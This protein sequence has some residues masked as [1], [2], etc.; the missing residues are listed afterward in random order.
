MGR[1]VPELRSR[2]ERLLD[3]LEQTMP[4]PGAMVTAHGDFHARQLLDLGGGLAIVDFD[5]ICVAPPALDLAGYA[6]HL[7]Y[8]DA[9]G[10]RAGD[11][12]RSTALVE[13]YGAA[14]AGSRLAPG[15]G[16]PHAAPRGRSAGSRR[17][18][19]SGSRR[20]SDAAEAVRAR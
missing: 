7:I 18:G 8:G 2:V 19:R 17:P 20:S 13:G 3:E 10:P 4:E 16:D 1:I 6:A 9:A 15:D 5:R 11:A 14:P 12:R